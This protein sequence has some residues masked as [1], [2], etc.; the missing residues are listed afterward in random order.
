MDKLD[1]L[2]QTSKRSAII[3]AIGI[4]IFIASLLYSSYHLF[5]TS[6]TLEETKTTL[7]QTEGRLRHTR[8][9][10]AAISLKVQELKKDE[11][12]INAYVINL[13]KSTR[14]NYGGAA[15]ELSDSSW[16][17]ITKTL[18]SLPSGRRKLAV[19]IA[20]L[21]TWK[22]IPFQLG[23]NNIKSSF[24]SP[25]YI[26]YVLGQVKINIKRQPN[27]PYSITLMKKFKKVEDPLPGDL[28]FYKGQVGNFGLIYLAPGIG[29]GTLQAS[30]PLGI[31]EMQ[32]MNTEYFPFVG[33]FRVD[34]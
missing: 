1:K 34:Y 33:Y 28:I 17:E 27:Q 25:G 16:N 13:L 2:Q 9:S 24:D 26:S 32:Y 10:L 23:K 11:S 14:E 8:D 31:Y 18:L 3:S 6:K 7:S 30:S 4:F 22:E 15:E 21:T 29:I 5:K 19:T 12:N 20:L